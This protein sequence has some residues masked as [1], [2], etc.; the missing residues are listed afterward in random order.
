VVTAKER[1]RRLSEKKTVFSPLSKKA[2]TSEGRVLPIPRKEECHQRKVKEKDIR[3][4][5]FTSRGK[6]TQNPNPRLSSV[7]SDPDISRNKKE[8]KYPN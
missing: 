2:N 8:V 5:L 3:G 4:L 7:I 1:N 6:E